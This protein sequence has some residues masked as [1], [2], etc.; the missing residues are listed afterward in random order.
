PLKKWSSAADDPKK[1]F[2]VPD[3]GTDLNAFYDRK[4]L[5]F[6]QDTSGTKTTFSGAST[7]VVAHECGHAFLDV[8][9]PELFVSTISEQG[10]FH[11]AFGDCIALLA[12]LSDRE[13][14][15]ALLKQ[16]STLGKANFVE[17]TAEDL[18]D[19]VKRALGAAHPA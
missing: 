8:L 13:T 2:L 16:S 4:H 14:R 18:S 9:R 6:F 7:D 5:A 11:E 1:L 15:V 17:A 19:G 10:A 12:A 3:G